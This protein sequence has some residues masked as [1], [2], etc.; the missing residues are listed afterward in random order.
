[1]TMKSFA[2]TRLLRSLSRILRLGIYIVF[3]LLMAGL[4]SAR[5]LRAD[6]GEAALAGGHQ[7]A[8]LSDLIGNAETIQFNGEWMHHASSYTDQDV[9]R[10]LDRFEAY[11]AESP[12]VFASGMRDLPKTLAAKIDKLPRAFRLGFVRTEARGHGM[13]ACFAN[14]APGQRLAL[15]ERLERFLRTMRLGEFG[16]FR[17]FYAE[18]ASGGQTH[19]VA[20][21]ADSELDIRAMFP[22][23]GDAA[24]TDSSVLPRPPNARRTLSAG[25]EGMPYGIRIYTSSDEA[26]SLW[27]FY[28]DWMARN[29]FSRIDE[30]ADRRG[31]STYLRGDGYQAFVVIGEQ[32]GRTSVTL[33]E[34]GRIGGPPITSVES[35]E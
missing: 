11:C 26:E 14:D 1:M 10:A 30:T 12:S 20:T 24:G 28:D 22:G 9:T 3:A 8:V 34:A 35:S 29:Q 23:Q 6:I 27:K 18:P 25:A 2:P 19:V 16:K 32:D 13:V 4:L 17:Y 33:T 5:V 31:A 21:W 15:G 7:L